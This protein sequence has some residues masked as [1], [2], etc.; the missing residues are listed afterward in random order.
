MTEYINT[1]PVP[2]FIWI[3]LIGFLLF[4]V[5]GYYYYNYEKDGINTKCLEEVA[6]SYCKQQPNDLLYSVKNNAGFSC[7]SNP[8]KV[9]LFPEEILEKCNLHRG[10]I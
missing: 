4:L 3:A 6:Q 8:E 10:I 2:I 5:L 9:F 7:Y 1:K